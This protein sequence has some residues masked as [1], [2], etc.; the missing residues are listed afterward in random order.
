M[1][2]PV[3]LVSRL[4][5]KKSPQDFDI[6]TEFRI[7]PTINRMLESILDGERKLIKAG[8]SLPFGS[9]LLV[10]AQR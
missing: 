5:S 1:L 4:I 8:A 9:S 3:A 10:V 2:L 6:L 7:H